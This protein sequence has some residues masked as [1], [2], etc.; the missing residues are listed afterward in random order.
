MDNTQE[1][2]RLSQAFSLPLSPPLT[3]FPHYMCVCDTCIYIYIYHMFTHIYRD[4]QMQKHHACVFPKLIY[5]NNSIS[6]KTPAVFF[7]AIH[8]VMLNLCKNAKEREQLKH[9]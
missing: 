8:K 5:R 7:V 6:I 4:V 1:K 3:S 2:Q 9:I